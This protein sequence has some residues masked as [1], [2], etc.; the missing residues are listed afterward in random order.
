VKWTRKVGCVNAEGVE[1]DAKFCVGTTQQTEK[2]CTYAG[3]EDAGLC[4]CPKCSPTAPVVVDPKK[5]T[6]T[7]QLG[8]NF[9][10]ITKSAAETFANDYAAR[11]RFTNCK[12]TSTTLANG[13]IQVTLACDDNKKTTLTFKPAPSRRQATDA[14]AT[15][16]TVE[17][18]GEEYSPDNYLDLNDLVG[19]INSQPTVVIGGVPVLS[20][21]ALPPL[22]ATPAPVPTPA[23]VRPGATPAPARVP[24]PAPV[25]VPPGTTPAPENTATAT[26]AP[27]DVTP[28]TVTLNPMPPVTPPTPPP[29]PPYTPP[30]QPVASPSTGVPVPAGGGGPSGPSSPTTSP[31]KKAPVGPIVPGAPSKSAATAAS[32][33]IVASLIAA[34]AV[35]VANI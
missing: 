5:A 26:E 23:P 8:T 18:V 13:N 15:G 4:D 14:P 19:E 7:L 1:V 22:E 9:S 28:P 20:A 27:V 31:P 29:R 10:T 21:T 3:A 11:M 33:S 32:A 35:A 16:A 34:V 12:T 6:T 2:I 25:K 17:I 30:P 24:T